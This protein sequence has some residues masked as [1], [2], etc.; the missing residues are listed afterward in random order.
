MAPTR[1]LLL[2]ATLLLRPLPAAELEP[3]VTGPYAVGSTNLEINP[4]GEAPLMPYLIGHLSSGQ[5]TY[6]TDLL[7]DPTA[8][9]V[10]QV[11]TA[12]AAPAG[13]P[14]ATV[15]HVLAIYYPTAPDN[16]RTSYPFPYKETGDNI[17]P[18]MQRGAEKPLFPRGAGRFPLIVY[19]G[20]YNTHGL[21]H[22]E[23]LKL[24]ASH[25]YIVVDI[26]HGDGRVPSMAES[27]G[28][29]VRAV[30]AALEHVLQDSNF[31]PAIDPER[32]G[33]A[34]ASAGGH[35]VAALLGGVDPV[36]GDRG[37]EPRIKAGFTLVPFLGGEMGMWPFKVKMW[38]FGEDH[39]G[40]ASVA[41]PFMAVYAED[42]SSCPPAGIERGVRAMQGPRF[43]IQLADEEHLLSG[44][45]HTDAYTWE[46]LFLDAY[47]RGS[48]EARAKL[49]AATS[50]RGGVR[51]RRT[52]ALP[53]N[54]EMPTAAAGAG[55]R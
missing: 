40:L 1:L 10:I 54:E 30:Q 46:L 52:I 24:V 11:P 14:P 18:H 53:G 50:V 55:G 25:G 29:R 4:P 36:Q 49:S 9:H 44:P 39:R 23:H 47:V 13:Q 22:L 26:F 15:P 32:I 41:A 48:A 3:V 12:P 16:E 2:V 27:R 5:L 17:F 8:V 31:G 34:G 6:L 19:S 37:H 42:D 51:D 45:A 38:V 33:V 35:T 20:G 28:L 7:A 21:W 43:A